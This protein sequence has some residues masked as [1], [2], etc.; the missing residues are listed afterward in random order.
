M[1]VEIRAE[2]FDPWAELQR[3]QAQTFQQGGSYGATAVFV[4]TMR[5]FNEG[6]TVRAM[7]LDH[8]PGMTERHLERI[9]AVARQ[10][11]DILDT[12]IIHRVGRL[13]P[14]DPIVLAAVWSARRGAALDA[15]GFLIEDLKSRAPFWKKEE[16]ETGSRWVEHNTD[17]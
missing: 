12:L 11:W 15:C 14:D 13:L 3:Y 2:P 4:G 16:L 1:A 9:S 5:H 17:R 7:T 10:R 6:G 8:Y